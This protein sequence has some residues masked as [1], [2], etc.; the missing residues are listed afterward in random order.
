[1]EAEARAILLEALDRGN[2]TDLSWVEQ[3]ILA[4]IRLLPPGT[5][6]DT[7]LVAAERAFAGLGVC[8]PLIPECGDAYAEIVA[9]RK[10]QGR[11]I[12]GLDALTAAIALVAGATVA[13]RD[14]EGF[15]GLGLDVIDPW[16]G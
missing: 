15:T 14:V 1:M 11:P 2:R 16:T 5:R 8:L 10:R 6:R 3:L 13:T 7:L 9:S 12:G 4:G